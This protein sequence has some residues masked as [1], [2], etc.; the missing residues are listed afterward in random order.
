MEKA[1]LNRFATFLLDEVRIGKQLAERKTTCLR[2]GVGCT[3]IQSEL[4]F[5]SV[6]TEIIARAFNGPSRSG[7][8]CTNVVG[9]CG[10]SHSEPRVIMKAMMKR[11][12]GIMVCTYSPCTNCANIVI[13]S[14]IVDGIVWSIL[15]E[16]DKRGAEFLRD[17][18]DVLTTDQ[19]DKKE[20]ETGVYDTLRRWS[21]VDGGDERT[22]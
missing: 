21:T 19:L 4:G 12:R 17:A 7:H 10:C 9:G 2:K 8:E 13:D 1:A 11:R 14:D 5:G 6:K 16:H 22:S 18:M 20:L 3:L 15:T